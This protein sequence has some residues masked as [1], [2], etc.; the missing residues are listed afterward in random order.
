M[1]GRASKVMISPI[2]ILG[3]VS[4]KHVEGAGIW[5]EDLM[6]TWLLEFIASYTFIHKSLALF[7]PIF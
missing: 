6:V 4:F 1:E 7:F 5:N 3:P 2:Y